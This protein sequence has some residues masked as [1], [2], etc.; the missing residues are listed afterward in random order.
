MFCIRFCVFTPKLFI[1][2]SERLG[3]DIY[4]FQIR[5]NGTVLRDGR[6]MCKRNGK[7]NYVK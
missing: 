6:D 1:N 5:K 7:A 2:M 4:H 3:V